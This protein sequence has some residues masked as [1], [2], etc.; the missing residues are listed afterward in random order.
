MTTKFRTGRG[1]LKPCRKTGNEQRVG[2]VRD[3]QET[4]S[5]NKRDHRYKATDRG[6][7]FK[8]QMH[9]VYKVEVVSPYR[10]ISIPP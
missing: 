8:Q 3:R 5:W 1:R 7:Q 10:S 6:N 9:F 2:L 4:D